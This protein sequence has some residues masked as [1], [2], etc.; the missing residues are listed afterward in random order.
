MSMTV[1][2]VDDEENARLNIGTFLENK[3]Y[4]VIGVAT[5]AEARSSLQQGKSI[6]VYLRYI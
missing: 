2:I 4:E 6:H 3:G 5:L 1:L